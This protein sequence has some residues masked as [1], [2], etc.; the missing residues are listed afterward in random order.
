MQFVDYPADQPLGWEL[1]ET[2]TPS[3]ESRVPTPAVWPL[4][5]DDPNPVTRR[6]LESLYL[7]GGIPIPPPPSGYRRNVVTT[8]F[9][10]SLSGVRAMLLVLLDASVVLRPR[11]FDL[12]LSSSK[13]VVH[14]VSILASWPESSFVACAKYWKDWP[15]AH[16]MGAPPP[17]CP[18]DWTLGPTGTIFS[19]S[20]G[21]FFRRV[22]LY[23][24]SGTAADTVFRVLFAISQ[25]KRGF[26]TVPSSFVTSTLLKHADQLSSPPPPLSPWDS[27]RLEIMVRALLK[28]FR[29]PSDLASEAVSEELPLGRASNY[30]T[31]PLGGKVSDIVSLMQQHDDS[32]SLGLSSTSDYLMSGYSLPGDLPFDGFRSDPHSSG[33]IAIRQRPLYSPPSEIFRRVVS[34]WDPITSAT[35]VWDR[36]SETT[37]F[38][39]VG[40]LDLPSPQFPFSYERAFGSSGLHLEHRPSGYPN[41]LVSRTGK[42]IP[43]PG[44]HPRSDLPVARVVPVL[45]PLKVRVITAMDPVPSAAGVPVQRALWTYLRR[46]SPFVLIGEE[47]TEPV[48]ENFLKRSIAWGLPEDSALVSADYSAATDGLNIH[49]SKVIHRLVLETLSSGDSIF[50]RTLDAS[51][52]EQTLLYENLIEPGHHGYATQR[53]GQLMGSILSFNVLCIANL[54]TWV[55]SEFSTLTNPQF[56]ERVN[57]RHFFNSLPCL[58]NGDDLLFRVPCGTKAD[59]PVPASITPLASIPDRY[60]CWLHQAAAIGFVTSPGKNFVHPTYATLNSRPLIYRPSRI[61][62]FPP[63]LLGKNWDDMDRDVREVDFLRMMVHPARIVLSHYLNVG[64]LLGVTKIKVLDEGPETIISDLSDWYKKTVGSSLSPERVHGWFLG[65]HRDMI[66]SLTIH[67]LG[68]NGP[69]LVL[70]LFAARS[71]GGLGF[72]LFPGVPFVFTDDQRRL[73]TFLGLQ[74]EGVIRVSPRDLPVT[75][76]LSTSVSLP[77]PMGRWLHPITLRRNPP[78]APYPAGTSLYKDSSILSFDPYRAP[79]YTPSEPLIEPPRLALT[80]SQVRLIKRTKGHGV[81]DCMSDS[82][83]VAGLGDFLSGGDDVVSPVVPPEPVAVVEIDTPTPTTSFMGVVEDWELADLQLN[84]PWSVRPPSIRRSDPA[85]RHSNQMAKLR[86]IRPNTG[87][88]TF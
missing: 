14:A 68:P 80:P 13:C 26:A 50:R 59:I 71:T 48:L 76:V 67:Q 73:G 2:S 77:A 72:P 15:L 74:V 79:M 54:Y 20:V 32:G 16:F 45:E 47:L 61:N 58:I 51:L 35:R 43:L 27:E 53:N 9:E 85:V 78:G 34:G 7:V 33:V 81:L 25:S 87:K 22:A 24:S 65:Y 49:V 19:G 28:G 21:D 37:G 46:F 12:G 84:L 17:K 56:R 64:L 66:R 38:S 31:R 70:N 1:L 40:F 41:Y 88:Q 4:D 75:S 29:L 42:L 57:R 23:P 8:S 11:E 36:R 62:P 63:H 39:P 6:S 5:L 55:S 82:A 52:L 3:R 69:R 18:S 10:Q 86:R 60:A 30:T 44:D 83:L